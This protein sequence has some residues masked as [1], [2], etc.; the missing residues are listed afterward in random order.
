MQVFNVQGMTCGHC[1]K[2]VTAA[3]QGQ[4]AK[5]EVKVDL[6]TRQVT[7]DSQ[8]SSE[9]ILAAIREEGYEAQSA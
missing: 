3:V 2:A 1:V 9:Q 6:A 4:D 8:L 7:V 5:A